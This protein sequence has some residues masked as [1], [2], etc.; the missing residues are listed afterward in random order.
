MESNFVK[1]LKWLW[2]NTEAILF[3]IFFATFTFNIRKVFLTPYSY[4]NREFNEYLTISFS[5]ADLLIILLMLIY[6]IKYIISQYKGYSSSTFLLKNKISD[7]SSI[8]LLKLNVSRET[9]LLLLFI[10]WVVISIFWSPLKEIALFRALSVIEVAILAFLA[11][12]F[13]L[14]N[15]A[16][17]LLIET[18]LIFGGTIQ[19][20]IAV[21][22]FIINKSLG[23]K[24]LGESILGHNLPG[25][26]KFT[27]DG[28]K[29]IRP[30]GTFPHPN[31][32]A[33][34][35]LAP[36]M[37]LFGLIAER[38]QKNRSRLTVSH[39]TIVGR[40]ST[41]ILVILLIF[42][43][44]GLFITFSRSALIAIALGGL[45]FWWQKLKLLSWRLKRLL[46]TSLILLLFLGGYFVSQTKLNFIFS[47]Q[48]LEE[49]NIYL[50]VSHETIASH[51]VSGL[52]MGQF[53]SREFFLHPDLPGWQ[54]QPVHNVYL[55][56]ASELG[57]IGLAL[58]LL[59]ILTTSIKYC[60]INYLSN[61]LTK[62]P[63]CIIILS[64]FII[65]F[66]D[67]YFWDI[68]QGMIIFT[69]P[70]ILHVAS[71]QDARKI[72]R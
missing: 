27:I 67:H 2:N 14:Q 61:L 44:F 71:R 45:I 21:S 51:P 33:G 66:F 48:S 25:V 46:L 39:E 59:F 64:F 42:L 56:I 7:K 13:A 32:L 24:F 49:R 58:F 54:Y 26:A 20:L 18:A 5:W 52:G 12:N 10:G 68:K 62:K 31:I 34:F 55:L 38:L 40:F 43:F 57:I 30:Y 37:I 60:F 11:F 1:H 47:E 63:Y 28:V 4:L 36:I 72:P 41:P 53:V 3:F 70:F 69:I 6:T 35:L 29:H 65:S 23:V 8:A 9:F 19:V 17:P 15:R 50:N 22:Q 16:R